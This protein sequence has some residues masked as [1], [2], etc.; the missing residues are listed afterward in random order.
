MKTNL[1]DVSK[2]V[3]AKSINFGKIFLHHAS[4]LHQPDR[5]KEISP[6]FQRWVGNANRTESRRDG[7]KELRGPLPVAGCFAPTRF[8]R[9][10]GTRLLAAR[11]PSDKSLGYFLSPS[12][13]GVVKLKAFV[14]PLLKQGNQF[15]GWTKI[16]PQAAHLFSS[17]SGRKKIAH[18]FNGE[19]AMQTESSPAGTAE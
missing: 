1:Q 11:D 19:V 3:R 7:R 14:D 18:R 5:A 2:K 10:C 9:P 15:F 13:A 12:R 6:P 17:P 4:E 16:I 8:C